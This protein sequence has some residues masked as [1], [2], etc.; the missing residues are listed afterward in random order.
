MKQIEKPNWDETFLIEAVVLSARGSCDRLRAA[1]VLVKNNRIVGAGYN[2][3][4]S[5]TPTC[6]EVGHHMKENH[7]IR[8]LHG[9]ENAILNAVADLNGATA[10][11]VGAPCTDCVRRLLQAG[12]KRIVN[13]GDLYKNPSYA[14]DSAFSQQ[15]MKEKGVEF[16]QYCETVEEVL[17][18]FAKLFK[19]LC[20]PGGIFQNVP[21]ATWPRLLPDSDYF[22]KGLTETPSDC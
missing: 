15:L 5:G 12:I 18:L 2:G 8:T 17:G 21:T 6:D 13:A 20:G 7:C 1:C 4:V 22:P 10:Y 19:R 9:E 14:K 11:L 3:S 16:V